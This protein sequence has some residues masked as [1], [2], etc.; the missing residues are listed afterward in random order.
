MIQPLLCVASLCLPALAQ[1]KE[2]P[3]PAKPGPAVSKEFPDLGLTVTLPAS[4][5]EVKEL[6]VGNSGQL[7]QRWSAKLGSADLD[8]QVYALALGAEFQFEEPE[9]VMD[10]V[11]DNLRDPKHGDPNYSF[12]D[13][14]LVAGKFGVCPYASLARG[15]V[16]GSDG[17]QE[18][19]TRFML[20]GMLEKF[21]YTVELVASPKPGPEGEKEIVH[22]LE[23]GIAY[24]GAVRDSKW[25]DAEV[26]AR[27]AKDAPDKLAA[28]PADLKIIRTAH[29]V[30]MTD[31]S[32][33][34]SFA[35]QMEKNYEA[36]KKVYPFDD[37]AGRLLMPVF[38]FK[39]PDEYYEYYAKQFESTE[40][41]A[42]K[43][44]GVA[45]GDWYATWY[46]SPGDLVHIH[47]GTHQIFHDRLRLPGGGSWFQEGV[48]EFMSSTRNDRNVAASSVRK[49]KHTALVDFIKIKSLLWSAAEDKK[50]GDEAA[51][52]YD[53]AALL[54]EFLHESKFGKDKFQDF[55]HTVGLVPRNSPAAI[56][57]AVQ[58]VYGTD[59]AGLDK[60]WVEYCKARK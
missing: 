13:Q 54:I 8:I 14:H 58:A 28:K 27:W 4:F 39:T 30:V 50:G 6:P 34:K 12:E 56:E 60:Q 20:G 37:V 36:I 24:K 32:G 38:L 29:Y 26:K 7:R 46:E 11:L 21:G 47:E 41:E 43:S 49:G 23:T 53:L 15:A 40:E 42:R 3:A 10:L 1:K 45:S 19:A 17:T 5:T 57:R 55:V 48:A 18:L 22:F 31:S 52:H 51:S 44:K 2:A 33:G 9:D 16:R 59:L 25:S 35:E